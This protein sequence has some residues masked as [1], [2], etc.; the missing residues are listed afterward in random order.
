MDRTERALHAIDLTGR[1]LEF[2]PSH[3]PL[4]PKASGARVETLDHATREELVEKYRELGVPEESLARIEEV[5]HLWTGEPFLELI[6]DHGAYDYLVASHFI[7]HT[8]DL[9]RFLKDSETLLA[10]GG[11]LALVVPDKRYCFDRFR[12]LTTLGDAID[13]MHS[14]IAFHPPGALVDQR[15]Y[16]VK[17]GDD[18]AWGRGNAG[19]IGLLYPDFAETAKAEKDGIAQ[20]E[21]I[22]THRW[23]FTPSSFEL[24]IH[25]LAL[26]GHHSLG[27]VE[28]STVDGHEFFVTLGRDVPPREID[29]L[30]LMRRVEAELAD[31]GPGSPADEVQ[32][33]NAEIAAL[34]ASTSWRLTRPLRAVSSLVGRR[35]RCGASRATPPRSCARRAPRARRS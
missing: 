21:Y 15:A 20:L 11:R 28:S 1:G 33:L 3:N 10:P 34:R 13:G 4:V 14:T 6:P 32:R 17:R 31:L 30:E 16:A 35:R 19:E 27:V 29:R 26:L 12:P 9:I 5:D 8:V 25:D 2:G 24:L 22:D 23:T 7:E 18:I